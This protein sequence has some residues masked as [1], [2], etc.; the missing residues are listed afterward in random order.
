[1]MSVKKLF[2]II[3][4]VLPFLFVFIYS[5][6]QPADPDLGWHLKY[7]EYFWQHGTVLRDNTFSTMMP[8]FHWANTSWLIDI[9]DYT[10]YHVGGFWGLSLLSSLVVTLTFYFFAKA[11]RLSLWEKTLVFPFIL[12][13]EAPVNAVS[14]RGQQVVLLF[15]GVL[16]YLI[17][18][19]EKKPKL[20]LLTIPLF[21]ILS[22]IDGEFILAYVLFGMWVVL[23]LAGK[24]CILRHRI[25]QPYGNPQ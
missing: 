17:S 12:Y 14:F 4:P 13:L 1:M 8:N 25:S 16:F 18:W 24:I 3:L 11:A 7:G 9:I 19:Y 22:A 23:Y 2:G 15:I 5:L 10:T 21:W 6:Y 20:L